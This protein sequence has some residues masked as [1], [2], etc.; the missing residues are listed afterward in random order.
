MPGTY[1]A[2]VYTLLQVMLYS[3]GQ[4]DLITNLV[5][6]RKLYSLPI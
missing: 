4:C 1:Q 3:Y 2:A 6:G 5:N